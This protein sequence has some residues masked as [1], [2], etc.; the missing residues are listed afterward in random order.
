MENKEMWMWPPSLKLC[1]TW[2]VVHL[3][4]VGSSHTSHLWNDLTQTVT[5]NNGWEVVVGHWLY[6]DN[7]VATPHFLPGF[8]MSPYQRL[9]RWTI[10]FIKELLP[11]KILNVCASHVNRIWMKHRNN[12]L[13]S[14]I[15]LSSY[16]LTIWCPESSKMTFQFSL[17][18]KFK[19]LSSL[20]S[21]TFN[22]LAQLVT[23]LLQKKCLSLSILKVG[24]YKLYPS[25]AVLN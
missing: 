11:V 18:D 8:Q 23:H 5:S 19:E 2:P 1:V 21:N 17:W 16:N 14:V 13:L 25:S 10:V 15:G 7:R 9:I 4:S 24:S 20:P 3:C 6:I 12:S 22:N